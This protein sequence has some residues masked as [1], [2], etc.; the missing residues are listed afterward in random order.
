MSELISNIFHKRE[1]PEWRGA[2]GNRKMTDGEIQSG[3]SEIN[4]WMIGFGAVQEYYF[5]YA[6]EYNK[7]SDTRKMINLYRN[8]NNN[9]EKLQLYRVINNDNNDNYVIKKFINGTFHVENDYLFQ[10]NPCR[11]EIVPQ[12]IIDECDKDIIEIEKNCTGKCC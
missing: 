9:Y 11:Y 10:L 7:V 1:E 4:D 2:E 3:M 12:Y 8:A 6:S 5:D